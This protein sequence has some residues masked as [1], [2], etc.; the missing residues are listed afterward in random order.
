MKSQRQEVCIKLSKLVSD[1]LYFT[2]SERSDYKD[3]VTYQKCCKAKARQISIEAEIKTVVSPMLE[4]PSTA[5]LQ[6][7]QLKPPKV[8][9]TEVYDDDFLLKKL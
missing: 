7:E 4:K 2:G 1:L 6:N 5:A 3:L 9:L 8:Q